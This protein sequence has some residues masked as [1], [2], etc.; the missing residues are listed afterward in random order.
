[1]ESSQSSENE[2]VKKH[3]WVIDGASLLALLRR[4]SAGEDPE[5][6][7]AD[8][9]MSSDIEDYSGPSKP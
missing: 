2:R 7:Y 4:C 1:M 9:Y 8:A 5:E 6:V 3:N